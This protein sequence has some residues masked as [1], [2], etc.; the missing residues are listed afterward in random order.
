MDNTE[1]RIPAVAVASGPH[2]YIYKNMRPYFKFTLP[3][4]EIHPAEKELWTAASSASTSE[5]A[6][7]NGGGLDLAS[8]LDGLQSLRAEIGDAKLTAR[9][10]RLLMINDRT[11]A[12]V[13][14]SVL[15]TLMIFLAYN[16]AETVPQI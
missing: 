14:L 11:E 8:L 6:G 7:N 1:P 5:G 4:L 10:Q 15:P 13:N 2:I 12:Q 3:T 16:F 9:T